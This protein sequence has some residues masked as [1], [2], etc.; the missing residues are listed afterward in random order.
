MSETGRV[1]GVD[2]GERRIGVALSD[3]LR[4]V[5][6]P[7][8]T[9]TI[10]N[11]KQAMRRLR[12]LIAEHQVQTLVV[13][14]PLHMDGGRGDLALAAEAFVEKIKRQL[15]QLEVH[16]WDERLSSVEAE[17]TLRHGAAKADR[18][19]AMRD[20]LAA[21]LILQSWLDAQNPGSLATDDWM[22]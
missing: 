10:E 11:P 2:Y 19:K 21:Q 6:T 7:L 9:I 18:R 8:E 13:G 1:M 12:E 4:T 22:D 14:H 5:G 3:S 15:P 16:L 20:Q 17:R